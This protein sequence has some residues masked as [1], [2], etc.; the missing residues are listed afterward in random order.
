MQ[1]ERIINNNVISALDPNGREVVIMGKGIGFHAKRGNIDNSMIEKIFYLDNQNALDKFKELLVNLPLKHIQVSNE[2]ISYTNM[3]LNKKINQNIY[4]TLT[5][6]INFAIE[7]YN[8]G[9]IFENP[10]LWE[11]QSLYRKEFLIG[12]YAVALI[13]KEIGIKLPI[14]EAASIALH[15]VNAE[16]DST[17]SDTMNITKLIPDVLRIVKEEFHIEYDEFSLSYE[18]FVNHLKLL[19]QRVIRKE[20]LNVLEEGFS[21][22]IR[23]MYPEEYHCSLKVAQY[24]KE[25]FGHE[26]MEEERSILTI[27]IRRL[28]LG[29]KKNS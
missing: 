24:F 4:I 29:I 12:E 3:V 19:A 10:L 21:N 9:L 22:T 7:R 28:I 2:I 23:N 26:I 6:H 14:D 20:Q 18:R 16:Y 5:D 1:V 17:M 27:N 13:N 15:I 8:Q 11:V 25:H